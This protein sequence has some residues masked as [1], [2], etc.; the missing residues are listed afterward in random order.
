MS[1]KQAV[2]LR[3]LKKTKQTKVTKVS[4]KWRVTDLTTPAGQTL[5]L[6]AAGF[7]QKQ[8]VALLAIFAAI[9]E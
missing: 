1:N 7:N 2:P 6:A 5:E 9:Q 8:K 3:P 4:G